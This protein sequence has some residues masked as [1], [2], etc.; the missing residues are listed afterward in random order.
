MFLGV[1]LGAF[2][3]HALKDKVEPYLLEVY[4]TGVLYHMLHALG[5]FAVAWMSSLSQDPKIQWAGI[6]LIA[7]IIFFS[8]SLYVMTLTGIR[9]F[10]AVTPIGGLCF[11]AA[12][13]LIF[14]SRIKF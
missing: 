8:G 2:G 12:W 9:V 7:G 1:A 13:M 5:L 4:K 3:A 6:L 14:A 11:L 10:G